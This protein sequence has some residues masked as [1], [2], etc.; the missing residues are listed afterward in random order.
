MSVFVVVLFY[1]VL[2]WIESIHWHIVCLTLTLHI[3]KN[4]RM[5]ASSVDIT[6][7]L[8]RKPLLQVIRNLTSTCLCKKEMWGFPGCA[9]VKNLPAKAGDVGSSPRPGGS[10]MPRSN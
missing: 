1:A 2:Q 3:P 7:I 10:H 8:V 6:L 5:Q 9:V 4:S